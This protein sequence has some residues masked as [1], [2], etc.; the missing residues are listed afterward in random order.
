MPKDIKATQGL[1]LMMITK[2]GTVKKSSAESFKD[3]R[4][5]GL[6]SIRLEDKDEL[7]LQC[8]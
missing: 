6:I 4:R 1:S 7:L 3:V 5:N 2:C 8:L